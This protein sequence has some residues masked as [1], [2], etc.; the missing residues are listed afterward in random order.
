MAD[1]TPIASRLATFIRLLS[2]DK[3][4]EIVAAA[5]AIRRTL[6][7]IGADIHALADRIEKPNG[8]KLSEEDMKRL[9]DAGFDDGVRAADNTA[10]GHGDFH[11]VDGTPSW[12]EILV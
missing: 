8:G 1:L 2:S 3:D 10:Y 9:Y 11:N 7:A 4:G 12:H 6:K 5:R